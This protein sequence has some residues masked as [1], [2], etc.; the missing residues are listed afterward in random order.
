LVT[1]DIDRDFDPDTDPVP[2]GRLRA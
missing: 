1:V 2:D